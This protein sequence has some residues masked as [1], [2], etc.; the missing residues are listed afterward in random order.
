VEEFAG[1]VNLP[2]FCDKK[3]DYLVKNKRLLVLHLILTY[4]YW[5]EF[6]EVFK[7]ILELGE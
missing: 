6:Y 4:L 2:N 3:V 7:M 5:K 1:R